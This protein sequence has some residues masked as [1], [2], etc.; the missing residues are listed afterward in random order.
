MEQLNKKPQDSNSSKWIIILIIV[1]LALIFI[2]LAAWGAYKYFY[3]KSDPEPIACTLEAKIC[4]DGSSVGR[5]AP[6]CEFAP[7]LNELIL[8]AARPYIIEHSVSGLEF[9]VEIIK[10]LDKWALIR[11]IPLNMDIDN[12]M[13]IM[14]KLDGRWEPRDIGTAF[15]QWYNKIPELF[16]Y[17]ELPGVNTTKRMLGSGCLKKDNEG[18]DDPYEFREDFNTDDVNTVIKYTNIEKGISFDISYNSDWGNED[19]EVLPYKEFVNSRGVVQLAF[20]KPRAWIGST[21]KLNISTSSNR[22]METILLEQQERNDILLLEQQQND[23]GVFEPRE[24]IIEDKQIVVYEI[25]GMCTS[26]IYEIIGEEYNYSFYHF[27]C[28][29]PIADTIKE[30]EETIATVEFID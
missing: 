15:P 5:I 28:E 9:D 10:L 3:Q 2:D 16:S 23:I 29:E 8:E 7:C 6:N 4:P 26:R 17:N 21:F 12:A 20:G 30:L 24:K 1:I 27:Y 11:T 18:F 22:F 13:V 19:C 25:Y 14:E